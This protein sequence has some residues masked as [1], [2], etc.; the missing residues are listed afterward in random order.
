MKTGIV[1]PPTRMGKEAMPVNSAPRHQRE[2]IRFLT[3]IPTARPRPGPWN[4]Y[5]LGAFVSLFV[6]LYPTAQS[7]AS[8][9]A[10]SST[11]LPP[12]WSSGFAKAGKLV[13][14]EVASSLLAAARARDGH[15]GN[16][17]RYLQ[18][19]AEQQPETRAQY[20]GVA[21]YWK[22]IV[23][24]WAPP[25]LAGAPKMGRSDYLQA[26]SQRLAPTTALPQQQ[27]DVFAN[28]YLET[29]RAGINTMREAGDFDAARAQCEQVLAREPAGPA[30]DMLVRLLCEVCLDARRG[31]RAADAAAEIRKSLG[32][33]HPRREFAEISIGLILQ[34]AKRTGEAY[35]QFHWF[36]RTYPNSRWISDALMGSALCSMA[37]DDVDSAESNLLA[38]LKQA[39]E[40]E[41]APR[42]QVIL[43]RIAATNQDVES[44]REI[45][46]AVVTKYPGTPYAAQAQELLKSLPEPA[47]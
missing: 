42:A 19:Q 33:H 13:S 37:L 18:V 31:I 25:T 2:G 41:H 14:R 16:V 6:L 21:D 45:L 46:Q 35:E 5:L 43:G 8:A 27:A 38:L 17:P 1:I 29:I 12:E 39:P 24:A 36:C 7:S 15:F 30:S 26:F 32:D 20:E 47:P 10:N 23:E 44:A 28:I 9:D 40:S 4:D 11:I 34:E 22:K 3:T